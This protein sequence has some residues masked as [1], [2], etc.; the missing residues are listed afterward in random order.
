M[1][2]LLSYKWINSDKFKSVE[3]H[4]KH[5]IATWNISEPSQH[6]PEDR[7][8]AKTTCVQTVGRMTAH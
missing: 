3:L 4:E 2:L 1:G 8:K 5:A 6:L 7:G